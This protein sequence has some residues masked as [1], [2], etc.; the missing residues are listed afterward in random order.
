MAQMFP[1]RRVAVLLVLSCLLPVPSL[2]QPGEGNRMRDL[3]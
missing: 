1:L 2:S 3:I